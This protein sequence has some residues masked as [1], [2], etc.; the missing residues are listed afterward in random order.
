MPEECFVVVTPILD[1]KYLTEDVI[2]IYKFNYLH[3]TLCLLLLNWFGIELTRHNQ[4][5]KQATLFRVECLIN[6]VDIMAV[7]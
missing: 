5:Q 2:G 6:S 7:W 3:D 4:Q 1:I